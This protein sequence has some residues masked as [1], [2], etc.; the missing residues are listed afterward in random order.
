MYK[1]DERIWRA[2][3]FAISE[4]NKIQQFLMAVNRSAT[5]E[6]NQNNAET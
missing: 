4:E 1:G 5:I 3:P 6:N 2:S